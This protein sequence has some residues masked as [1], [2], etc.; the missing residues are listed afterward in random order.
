MMSVHSYRADQGSRSASP[1]SHAESPGAFA[2]LALLR[3]PDF[4]CGVQRNSTRAVAGSLIGGRPLG[5][6]G[7]SIG[8]I[9][10]VQIII[11]KHKSTLYYVRTLNQEADME[12][13]ITKATETEYTKHFEITCGK[14]TAYVGI[15]KKDGSAQ[16]C[17]YNASHK[18]WRGMGKHF[19]TKDDAMNNYRSAEM[20]AIIEAAYGVA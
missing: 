7:L 8:S 19:S 11:D 12:T 2:R 6:L 18:A 5:R 4:S 9:L 17:S 3:Y 14:T 20:K 10:P 15:G 13:M 1:L 16:V